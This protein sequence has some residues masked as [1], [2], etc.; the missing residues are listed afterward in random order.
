MI[1]SQK[2]L[3]EVQQPTV[4]RLTQTEKLLLRYEGIRDWTMGNQRTV[5]MIGLGVVAIVVG[6]LWY[7]GQRK[8][9]SEHAATYLSRVLPYSIQGEYRRAIDGDM[10]R[11]VQGDPVYGLSYIVREF[12][13]TEAGSQAALALG[14][15]YYALGNY[16]S[17]GIAFDKA[18]SDYPLVLASIEAGRA[19]I[20]EHSGNKIE[21]AKLLESAA[22][23]DKGNPLN[24]DYLLAAARDYDQPQGG[25]RDDAIRIYREI[26]EVYP[27]TQFDDA[28]RRE[29][30]K[31]NVEL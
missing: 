22:R 26:A 27:S 28:A 4:E 29:L 1:R 20:L 25:K 30:L 15:A 31:L 12:G 8:T 17:A 2:D 23:R 5:G 10:T 3:A 14:N 7:V 9:N 16:D 18:S 24:A 21:A 6:I 13:S 11:R 19:A